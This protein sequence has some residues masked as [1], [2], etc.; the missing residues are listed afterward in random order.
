MFNNDYILSVTQ[1]NEYVASMLKRDIL[2]ENIGVRGEISGLVKHSSGHVFFSL[3]DA[4]ALVRCTMFKQ[5][6]DQIR[7]KLPL[8]DGMQVLVR[9]GAM[10]YVKDG[11]FRVNVRSIEREGSGAIFERF[12]ELKKRLEARGLFDEAHKK[13]LPYLPQCIG[14]ITSPTGAALQDIINITRRRFPDMNICLCPVTVQGASA[15]GEIAEAIRFMNRKKRADVLI[16]GRGGGSIEDLWAFNEEIVAQAI[17]DSEIPIVSAVGHETDFSISDFTADMRA[18]TPSAAAELCVPLYDVLAEKLDRC[19]DSILASVQKTIELKDSCLDSI[20]SS[21]VLASPRN[22]LESYKTRL[23]SGNKALA[24][25]I[26]GAADRARERLGSLTAGL[27]ALSPLGVLER[28]YAVV[29]NEKGDY[30]SGV[31]ALKVGEE[32]NIIM[33]DGSVLV[34]VDEIRSGANE[35]R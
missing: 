25:L 35:K 14:V 22:I 33:N 8:S 31:N 20:M 6:A 19:Q 7:Y 26:R 18:P 23:D 5:Y 17:Y 16:V 12:S 32:A 30:S 29:K 28:G 13:A 1:L 27:E 24:S 34:S 3:K 11:Q 15:A 21:A 2:L 9:G 4:N 10:I